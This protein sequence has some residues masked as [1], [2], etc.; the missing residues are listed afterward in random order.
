MR[1]AEAEVRSE[2]VTK[3]SSVA[4]HCDSEL[5]V[6]N[7]LP[8]MKEQIANDASQ[9][10]KGALAQA[11]CELSE[12]LKRSENI[13][14]IFPAVVSILT[15]ESV[16]E[17]RISLLENLSKL[18]T[19]VGEDATIEL[20]IPEIEKLSQDPTWRVR[21]ATIS[22][23]PKLL[24]FVSKMKFTQKVLPILLKYME[25]TVHQIR[26]QAVNCLL[27]LARG[28]HFD[29]AW[30]ENLFAEKLSDSS[31]HAKFAIRIHT[32]FTVNDIYQA[33]SD[34]F[35]NEKIY[36]ASMKSLSSDPVPNIRFNYAKTVE[37][38][39]SRLSNSNKMHVA[40]SLRQMAKSD[41]DFDVKYF[42]AKA[43]HATSGEQVAGLFNG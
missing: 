23:I 22:F 27:E 36:A 6:E 11:L 21:L 3:V 19:S 43:L 12:A 33:I 42:A 7:I 37:M 8:I 29:L 34:R 24:D 14:H 25:D 4:Q 39:Y 5:V 28:D 2:A 9:H 26:V 17:V 10:V 31:S 20:I 35:L 41:T 1:D 40:D 15:K 38:I 13:D 32:L 30:L 16:T 18:A